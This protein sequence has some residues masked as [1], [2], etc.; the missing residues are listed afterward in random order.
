MLSFLRTLRRRLLD[1]RFVLHR[2]KSTSHASVAAALVMGGWYL[3]ELY[4]NHVVRW[5]FLIIMGIMALVKIAFLIWY[6]VRD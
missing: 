4:V 6:K 1:E 5:D 3:Y 2:Y